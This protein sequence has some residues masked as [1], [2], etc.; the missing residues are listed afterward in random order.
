MQVV[1]PELAVHPL[2]LER[3]DDQVR[4]LFERIDRNDE[5]LTLDEIDCALDWLYDYVVAVKQTHEGIT[6]LQ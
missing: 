4:S 1:D 5:T 3:T 6:T 2:R